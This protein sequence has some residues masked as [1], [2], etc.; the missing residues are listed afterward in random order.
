DPLPIVDALAVDEAGGA[1]AS[2]VRPARRLGDFEPSELTELGAPAVMGS[3][4]EAKK[5]A[6][7]PKP[8]T[9]A[10]LESESDAP[11]T[12][13]RR[14]L[15]IATAAVVAMA[16][17]AA[18]ALLITESTVF[19]PTHPIPRLVGKSLPQA[20]HAVRADHFDVHQAG[21]TF[22]LTLGPGLIVSQRPAPKARGR[23]VTAKEGATISVV[24]SEG[25][26]PVA[27]PDLTTFSSCNDAIRALQAV[28]LVGACPPSAAQYSSTVVYG[29]VLGTSPT[30]TAPYGSTVT[31]VTS[32]GH[33]PVAIPAVNG[34]GATYAT[35][36]AALTA[37]GFVPAENHGYHPTVPVGQV[38]GTTPGPGAG[39][40][41][42]GSTVTVTISLGPQPVTIPSSV[43]G[44]SV[45][46]A[47]AAL[48]ALGLAVAGP[49]GPPGSTKV[50]STD[51]AVGASVLP[52]TTVNLYTL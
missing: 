44:E 13:R 10:A 42:F 4:K 28:H 47:T 3:V 27:I 24:V 49:Y 36:S 18:G 32:K 38:I 37:A 46:Q 33:A 8:E 22:S 17:V 19:T 1:D 23:A 25:L 5:S 35:A 11:T 7:P 30:G 51:P 39:P 15:W 29:A 41:P 21:Q 9:V 6:A 50:L 14:W 34:S 43:I 40:Q 12:R 45:P 20:R 26:P 52:G 2:S 31:I 48:Q 16:L